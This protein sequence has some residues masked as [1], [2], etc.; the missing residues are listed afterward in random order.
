M[1]ASGE[2]VAAVVGD[3]GVPVI[4]EAA[5]QVTYITPEGTYANFNTIDINVNSDNKD[6]AY[7][8]MNWRLSG[9]L[10][11]TTAETLNEAPTNST[12]QLT[13]EQ[14][15]NKTYGAVAEAAKALDYSFINPLMEDWINQWNLIINN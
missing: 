12:V 10:Q 2:I 7:E 1:F 3:Y 5:P 13:Q 8:Y 15:A 9:E 4:K 14:A 6:L 11:A